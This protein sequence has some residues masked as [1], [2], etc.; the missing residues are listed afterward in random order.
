MAS[1]DIY[2]TRDGDLF[3]GED[4]TLSIVSANNNE[5]FISQIYRRL[6]SRSS[7][8]I[9][10]DVIAANLHDFFGFPIDKYLL[11]QVKKRIFDTLTQDG[12][13]SFD[14]FILTVATV[15]TNHLLILLQV[16]KSTDESNLNAPIRIS[17][18]TSAN[19]LEA[20]PIYYDDTLT[21]KSLED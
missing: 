4:N 17:L 10:S 7:D 8:W 5:L 9:S 19:R 21:L 3:F 20:V 12:L 16:T 15:N 14:D 13:M 6:L 11:E 18:N 2:F 1:K